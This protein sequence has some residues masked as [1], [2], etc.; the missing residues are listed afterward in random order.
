[1]ADAAG[2]VINVTMESFETDVVQRSL[3]ELV[4]ID[5]WA[6]WCGP[7][8]Q[9]TPMLETLAQE[10]AGRMTLAKVN[11]DEQPELAGAFGVQSIPA[12]MAIRDGQAVDHFVGVLPESQLHEWMSRLLP[13][14]AE[15]L[16]RRGAALEASDPAAAEQAYREALH[17]EPENAVLTI[18]L[19]RV[20]LAQQ[21]DDECRSLV[22]E[23][24]ARGYLEP[25]AERLKSQLELRAAAAEAGDVAAARRAAQASPDDLTLQLKLAEALAGARKFEEA[26]QICLRIIEREREQ[27]VGPEAKATM[28]RI[29]ETLGGGSEL[30]STYRRKLATALY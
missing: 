27:G 13:S 14:P 21:R 24:E 9:L 30:T 16:A 19:A 23:L 5:F 26:L 20:L 2:G 29:F 28:L 12:V 6:P 18:A 22:A 25:E 4:V 8:R 3:R 7:C 1:M 11:V 15:E 17:L 10:N